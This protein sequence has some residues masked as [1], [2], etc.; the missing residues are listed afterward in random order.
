MKQ[1][2]ILLLLISS[3][4]FAQQPYYDNVN[5][6]LTGQN[7]YNELMVKI[8]TDVVTTYEYGDV[9]DDFLIMELDPAN[10]N[11][12]LLTYGFVDILACSG[13]T[14]RRIRDKGDFGGLSCE[15]NREHVFARSNADPEMGSVSNS[16]TGIAADPHNL[17]A[18]DVN[19]NGARG[20]KLFA[21]GSG[22]SGDVG[23][24]NWYPGDEWKGDIARIMMYMYVRYGDRCL[25][26]LNAAGPKEGATD[27]LQILLQWNAEDQVSQI[28]DNRN[29]HLEG[30][31]GN[32]NP[33]ID[34]P[35]L[36]T[37]IWGGI[38][39]E[40]RWGTLSAATSQL[41]EFD[42]YPNP[43]TSDVTVKLTSQEK[44]QISIYDILGK[45]VYQTSIFGTDKIQ[46]STLKSGVYILKIRQ[47]TSEI[48]KKLIKR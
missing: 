36:A 16:D 2:Y 45:R 46:T 34:N 19:R 41:P 6:T 37:I 33:F 35:Y 48:N 30:V 12:V 3:L 17:R 24:G 25:P 13:D 15:Y 1:I 31:Y 9:R 8:N 22:N 20:N 14:D 43:T 38:A 7:L 42:I 26:E 27:M 39:A 40:D 47:G 28:E 11:N 4:C 18:T 23:S 29:Q 44:T 5:L 32:R 10:S 21:A